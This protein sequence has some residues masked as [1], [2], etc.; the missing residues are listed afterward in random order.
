LSAKGKF[1]GD[2]ER[3]FKS[4][5]RWLN[6]HRIWFVLSVVMFV[7]SSLWIAREFFRATP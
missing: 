1:A 4:G 7:V 6:G 5:E 2:A 3:F